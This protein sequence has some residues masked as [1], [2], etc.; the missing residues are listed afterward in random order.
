MVA[1]GE[2]Q[3]YAEA[4]SSLLPR[5]RMVVFSGLPPADDRLEL[6]LNQLHYFEQTVV[7]A[8]GC[9]H[10]HGVAALNLIASGSVP[11]ADM[12][13]HRMNLDQLEEALRLVE[14]RQSMKILLYPERRAKVCGPRPH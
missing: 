6:S 2:R 5:G 11:V 3:A 13:S 8:Y 10:R 7:G 14:Q 9:A 1:V 4:V 12:I